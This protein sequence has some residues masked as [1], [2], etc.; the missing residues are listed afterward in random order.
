[1]KNVFKSRR[2]AYKAG[3]HT[4]HINT[5]FI[6]IAKTRDVYDT[7]TLNDDNSKKLK[8]NPNSNVTPHWSQI[9]LSPDTSSTTKFKALIESVD[10]FVTELKLLAKDCRF[11][12]TDDMIQD[13]LAF[14]GERM[15]H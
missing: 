7:Q 11:T 9:L 14:K 2:T 15:S 3:L 8:K 4:C 12:N 5:S 13:C 6:I 1:M 10:Q